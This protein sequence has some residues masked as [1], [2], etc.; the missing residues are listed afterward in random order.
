MFLAYHIMAGTVVM[1]MYMSPS[2]LFAISII[3]ASVFFLIAGGMATL[4]KMR[5]DHFGQYKSAFNTDVYSQHH[6]IGMLVSRVLVAIILVAA[7]GADSVSF[8]AAIFP[9]AIIVLIAVKKPYIH[10]YNNIRATINEV[11][12]IICL[13]IYGYYRCAVTK[14]D[15]FTSLNNMLPYLVLILLFLS[16]LMNLATMGKYFY[17]TYQAS[18]EQSVKK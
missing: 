17:D 11:V 7:S 15:K 12:V 5:P 9:V 18:K 3:E 1:A 14:A 2:S 6:Y 16:E 10:A 13:A 8:I 4:F